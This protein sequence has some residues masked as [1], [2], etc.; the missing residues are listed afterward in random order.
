MYNKT[1]TFE[2]P[3]KTK[4]ELQF[5]FEMILQVDLMLSYDTKKVFNQIAINFYDDNIAKD[6]QADNVIRII[7]DEDKFHITVKGNLTQTQ[8]ALIWSKFGRDMNISIEEEGEITLTEP[9]VLDTKDDIVQSIKNSLV[10]EE[11]EEEIELTEPPK[12]ETAQVFEPKEEIQPEIEAIEE[13]KDTTPLPRQEIVDYLIQS[14]KQK[15]FQVSK[16]EIWNFVENYRKKFNRYLTKTDM[17][18]VGIGYIKMLNDEMGATLTEEDINK[19]E[20]LP[21]QQVE[22]KREPVEIKQTPTVKHL[23][24]DK[25]EKIE[26][27]Q[28]KTVT[29]RIDELKKAQS[30][31]KESLQTSTPEAGIQNISLSKKQDGMV[32]VPKSEGRRKC[33]NC[34]ESK[35]N[36]I[37]ESI[38]KTVIISHFPKIYGKKYKCGSCGLEWREQ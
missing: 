9:P 22:V 8:V 30:F 31:V 25:V 5:T 32:V 23:T 1:R 17:E 16:V 13:E 34:Q 2:L 29:E 36:M 7:Q 20:A 19:F 6:L 21:K 37:H 3:E 14:N 27:L 11:K 35:P 33:P 15:G 10:S 18:S 4:E 28:R 24:P 12:L 38:D 26:K